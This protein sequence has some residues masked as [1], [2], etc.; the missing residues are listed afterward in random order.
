MHV[1]FVSSLIR[2]VLLGIGLTSLLAAPAQAQTWPSRP[3]RFV[4]PAPGGSSPDIV[5]RLIADKLK[6]SLGQPVVVD[7]RVGAGGTIGV[8][9]VA[10]ARDGHTI[11]LGYNGPLT[12]APSLFSKLAYDP[13]RDLA[14]IILAATQPQVLVVRSTLGVNNFK[15]WVSYVKARPGKLNYASVGNGSLSHLTME[16]MKVDAGVFSVHIPYPGGPQAAQAIA[17]GEVD[18]GFMALSNVQP[19][20]AAGKIKILALS[21]GKRSAAIPDV[22]TIAELG[23]KGFDA[24]TWNG[25]LAPV[26]M[27]REHVT[28][29]NKLIADIL[30][31]PDVRSR[32]LAAGAEPAGG[33]SEDFA[34]LLKSEWA[35]WPAVVKRSGA[36]VD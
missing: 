36:K 8:D 32:M 10:K 19:L 17:A 21:N 13:A 31:M 22:P 1:R 15:D 34:A 20:V 11:L 12:V 30:A 23:F 29:L 25:I 2:N 18:M 3:L 7:N 26:D 28:R 33:S 9:N 16:T 14:P 5:A 6:D 35:R 4:V 24:T 27:P